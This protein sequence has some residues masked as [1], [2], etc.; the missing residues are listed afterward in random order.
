MS[1][2]VVEQ[3]A[4]SLLDRAA[5]YNR[6]PHRTTY[7]KAGSPSFWPSFVRLLTNKILMCNILATVFC[8]MALL[9]F[10]THENIFLE[11]RFHIARPTGMLLG[12]SDPLQSRLITSKRNPYTIDE[13]RISKR[14]E[15]DDNLY[16][17]ICL[18]KMS[19]ILF[20]K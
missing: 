1:I 7:Q 17:G 11:S 2:Q 20:H 10:M 12:F 15:I 18:K 13:T 14:K 6:A 5:V 16:L 19:I 8:A 3:A 9:N 4:A